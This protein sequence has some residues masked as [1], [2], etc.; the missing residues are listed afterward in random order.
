MNKPI[1]ENRYK[2]S[3]PF[4]SS[5]LSLTLTE[6][7]WWITSDNYQLLE[8]QD[9]APLLARGYRILGDEMRNY[10]PCCFYT[11][12][13]PSSEK[14]LDTASFW[15]SQQRN[16]PPRRAPN[17]GNAVRRWGRQNVKTQHIR[18]ENKSGTDD[19]SSFLLHPVQGGKSS[20]KHLCLCTKGSVHLIAWR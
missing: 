14:S 18:Y 4:Y 6:L 13:L 5:T 12:L 2:K 7:H 17:W 19:I 1:I 8:V 20:S 3:K 15:P 16:L 9:I 11:L 10:F